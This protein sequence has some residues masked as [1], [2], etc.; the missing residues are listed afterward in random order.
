[1]KRFAAYDPPEY[2]QW[3]PDP[4]VMRQYRD[5][6][7]E[8]ALRAS[9]DQLSGEG[10]RDLYR[11]L[12]RARLHDIA[13][14]RWVKTGV[15]TKA[16]LGCGEEAATVGACHALQP[17]DVVGPMI[18]NA[19]ATFER[20]IPIEESFRSYLA[21]GDGIT[22]GRD[23]HF[24]DLD[25]GVVAPISHVGDLVPV[26]SGFALAF[27]LEKKANVALTWVGDGSTRTGA[28][29]EGLAMAA[30]RSLPL[31]VVVEDNLVALGTRR[32]DRLARSL[33]GMAGSY[34]A[35]GL[36]CDGNHVI[37][38]HATV[39]RARE[40]CLAGEGPVVI[41]ARTFRF[42]GHATHD[43][44]EARELFDEDEFQYWA[45]KEPIGCYEEG[46]KGQGDLLGRDPGEALEEWE[47][48]VSEE[49]ESAAERALES[50]KNSPPDINSMRADVFS[51]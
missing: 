14:K 17:G 23:L 37:D 47:Q 50:R 5:R 13:L 15:L 49:V 34:G 48:Q 46:L 39:T 30:S 11:G 31:I 43:E 42:G 21:T 51:G 22:K 1:M 3:E 29:H 9:V 2:Q 4:E 44:A 24:G 19:A 10:L 38:V 6:I 41:L 12:L 32:D 18:R 36:Q 45:K 8:P 35:I 26:C 33:E 20:G 7:E 25:H 27:Q 40:H 16:W 28:V